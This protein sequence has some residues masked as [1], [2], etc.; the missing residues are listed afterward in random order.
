MTVLFVSGAEDPADW[1]PALRARL[2]G[3]PVWTEDDAFDRREV[4]VAIVASPP[5]G[6]LRELPSLRLVQSLWMGVDGLLADPALPPGV[7][8]ARMVDP[9][10]TGQMPEAALAHVLHLHRAHDVYG[11]QQRAHTWRQWPQPPAGRRRVGVLGL[12]ELGARTAGVL[13]RHGFHV[14]GW[15]RT[16]KRIDGVVTCSG[17]DAL[18]PT[19]AESDILVDLLPLTAQT[20]GLL[21]ARRLSRLPRGACLVNL[22]RGEHVLEPDLL[23]ALDAGRLRHAILD[24]FAEEPLPPEHP[25]WAHPAVTVLP[26]VAA[27]SNPETCVPV[28]LE[29][30]RRLAA[31]EPLLHLVDRGTGY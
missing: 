2:P 26:H 5:A 11:R 30:L 13:A 6:A 25:Y 9:G 27:Q 10:M 31:G 21:D 15:S 19:L 1:V 7:P 23:A 22:A 12:G 4:E 3:T 14:R 24:A 29:N 17:P 20:R 16:P 8:V 18:D 28:V